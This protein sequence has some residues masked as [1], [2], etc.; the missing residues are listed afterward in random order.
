MIIYYIT[1][2]MKKK[3]DQHG[4]EIETKE[5]LKLF[6][7]EQRSKDLRNIIQNYVE[8]QTARSIYYL[9]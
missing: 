8:T 2:K 6:R 1:P 4:L 7:T 3:L 9:S 5:V